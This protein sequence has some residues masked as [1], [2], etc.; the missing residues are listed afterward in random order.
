MSAL[1]LLLENPISVILIV[2][3]FTWTVTSVIKA[4][5]SK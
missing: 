2:S 3:I 5:K 4:I 1:Q